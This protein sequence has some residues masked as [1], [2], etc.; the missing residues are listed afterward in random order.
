[1][2]PN[3]PQSL[4]PLNVGNVVSAGLSLW[5]THFK[6]YIGLSTKAVLWYLVPIYGW[7]RCAMIVGQIGRL[8]FQ[9]VIHQPETIRDALRKVEPRMWSFLGVAILVTLIQLALNYAISFA[10]SIL[11]VP[12]LAIGG[13][14]ESAAVLSAILS[15]IAQLAIFGVQMW[16]QARFW[17][18]DI[19]I[20]VETDTDAT[21]SISRSWELTSGSTS[22]VLVVLLI[23][24]LVMMPLFILSLVPFLF[25]LPFFLNAPLEGANTTLI[26]ALLLAFLVF[27]VLIL[28]TGVIT[29]PF[30]QSIKSVL[31]YDL[32]SRREGLDIQIRDPQ[33][34]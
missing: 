9:E 1:M 13:A 10:G 17:L 2:T 30:W 15:V 27:L 4:R 7:A 18:Y 26:S 25:T 34:P 22:R 6:T 20:A 14:G 19:I 29:I 16:I 32:R 12:I 8:G 5:R 11:L 33:R 28:I 23:T 21:S 24:Y 3:P 31:Y